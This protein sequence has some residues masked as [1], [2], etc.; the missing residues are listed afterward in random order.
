MRTKTGKILSRVLIVLL[1]I[2]IPALV[3]WAIAPPNKPTVDGKLDPDNEYNYPG[4]DNY[5]SGNNPGT[6]EM[7]SYSY[8]YTRLIPNEGFY[9][10]NDWDRPV[11]NYD[12]NDPDG[13]DGFNIF[14]WTV[15]TTN[16][17]MMVFGNGTADIE[18]KVGSNWEDV[19]P[20]SF[21]TATGYYTSEND[22]NTAHPIWEFKLPQEAVPAEPNC[23]VPP[24]TTSDPKGNPPPQPTWDPTNFGSA[25]SICIPKWSGSS[26]SSSG[27]K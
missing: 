21:K 11:T 20:N 1:L 14:T 12:P 6:K 26:S 5:A 8:L 25:P 9:V 7:G 27:C 2:A 10:L 13:N 4:C 24:L 16:W 22:P 17:R 3:I 15:G 19:D 23:T 18:K